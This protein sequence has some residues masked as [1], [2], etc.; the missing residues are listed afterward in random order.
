MLINFG[1]AAAGV[2]A[3]WRLFRYQALI[4]LNG[5]HKNRT[6]HQSNGARVSLVHG[7]LVRFDLPI[8]RV[9]Q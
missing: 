9:R 3:L 1:G 7:W 5:C 4:R 2:H 8:E 6:A